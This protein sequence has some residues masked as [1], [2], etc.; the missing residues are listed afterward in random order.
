M[1]FQHV[2]SRQGELALTDLYDPESDWIACIEF[3]RIVARND[4]TL[5][6]VRRI[7]L[8]GESGALSYLL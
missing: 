5:F 1:S 8:K 7:I 2:T 6:V 3:C 4:T